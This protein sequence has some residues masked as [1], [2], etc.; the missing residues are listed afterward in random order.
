MRAASKG[1]VAVSGDAVFAVVGWLTAAAGLAAFF[2]AHRCMERAVA[3]LREARALLRA[4]AEARRISFGYYGKA[5]ALNQR[6]LALL[7]GATPCAA[8]T[9][10]L[11][12]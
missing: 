7:N 4:A 11:L 1:S 8:S 5:E 2:A 12:S 10:R 9:R 6:T 3:Q